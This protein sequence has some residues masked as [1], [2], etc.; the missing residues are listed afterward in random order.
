MK[1]FVFLFLLLISTTVTA[2]PSN[3]VFVSPG[4]LEALK[5]AMSDAFDG[6]PDVET[7]I[8]TSGT[9]DFSNDTG[10]PDTQTSVAIIGRFD[11]IIFKG[12]EN[13]P[14]S[15]LLVRP[16]GRLRLQNIELVGFSLNHSGGALIDNRGDLELL[17]VQINSLSAVSQCVGFAIVCT[18]VIRIIRNA[19]PGRIFMDQVS[20]INSGIDGGKPE[21]SGGI[22]LNDGNAEIQNTQ[23]YLAD[24][25]SAV[26]LKNNG[27]MHLKNIS[28]FTSNND[29][30]F[31]DLAILTEPD[32]TTQMANSIVSGF[33]GRTCEFVESLGH[34][35]IDSGEC[36]FNAAGDTVGESSGLI[37][38]PVT[39][40]WGWTVTSGKPI[41]SHALIPVAASKAVDSIDPA[42]CTQA[43]LL[44]N[45]WS[46]DLDGNGDG[47]GRCD[48]GAVE[49]RPA[50]LAEGGINGL[51]YNPE[52]DGHYLSIIDNKYNTLLIWNSFDKNGNQAWIYGIG[53][54]VA[55]RSLV[56]DAYI[57]KNGSL[58]PDGEI[59]PADE[60]RWGTLELDMLSCREGTLTFQSDL[61]EFGSGQVRLVRLVLVKQLGCVD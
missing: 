31:R 57:K 16:E 35:L 38:R 15:L 27:F 51:Y 12:G 19:P 34:N 26:P 54:L 42:L 59:L 44:N 40:A 46:R 48:K 37:W 6:D 58:S 55:G 53:K 13:S 22:L 45:T 5:Q 28:L 33:S 11:P 4:D 50:F 1:L 39:N 21:N 30:K 49:L 3:Q 56:A 24:S 9:F 43:D 14:A 36:D 41:L 20:V 32:G 2:Q 17:Q 60:V 18:P 25:F 47:I 61:P 23:I 10:L 8:I 7:V 29:G 52:A